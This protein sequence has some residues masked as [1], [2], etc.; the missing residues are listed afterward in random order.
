MENLVYGLRASRHIDP[1]ELRGHFN[2]LE[3]IV[4]EALGRF[5]GEELDA[6]GLGADRCQGLCKDCLLYTSDAADDMQ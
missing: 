6:M 1:S 5:T 2:T 4:E 3:R